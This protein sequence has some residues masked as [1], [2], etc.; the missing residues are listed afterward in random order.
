MFHIA[1]ML[2]HDIEFSVK[3]VNISFD[4]LTGQREGYTLSLLGT[5]LIFRVP[6]SLTR[7]DGGLVLLS[8]LSPK[9]LST[10]SVQIRANI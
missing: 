4:K 7:R 10:L 3:L 2:S 9:L 6:P 8:A 5:Q 1:S